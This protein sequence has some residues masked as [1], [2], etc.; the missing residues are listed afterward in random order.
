MTARP[1]KFISPQNWKFAHLPMA[2]KMGKKMA[3]FGGD[4]LI[5]WYQCWYRFFTTPFQAFICKDLQRQFCPRHSDHIS[6]KACHRTSF[7]LFAIISFMVSC[8]H[9]LGLVIYAIFG[10]NVVNSIVF[11]RFWH[12]HIPPLRQPHRQ[13]L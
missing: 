10:Y 1:C 5:C 12:D 3:I 8:Y 9:R 6:K 13:A 11:I 2:S 4:F 7:F